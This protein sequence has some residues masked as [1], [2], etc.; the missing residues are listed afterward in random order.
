MN[1]DK[2]YAD[3]VV[4]LITEG[5]HILLLLKEDKN[6]FRDGGSDPSTQA[7]LS[8]ARHW[9]QSR[10]FCINCSSS[11]SLIIHHQ[12]VEFQNATGCPTFLVATAGPWITVLGVVI[13]DGVIVQRLMDCVWIGID[14]AL[15]V[16]RIR[17]VARIFS[18]LKTGLGE[19]HLY[20]ESV[21]P[22]GKLP[23]NSRYF[24]SITAYR[25]D[26]KLVNFEFMGYLENG[27]DC[28]TLR[29]QTCDEM[30]RRIVVKFVEHHGETAHRL[31]ADAGLAP[32]LFYYG[33]PH[34]DEGQPSY[35]PLLM[36][37]ME[38]VEGK[39]LAIAKPQMTPKMEESVQLELQRA[40][41]IL[42]RKGMVFGD[43]RA[44]LWV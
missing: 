17:H 28:V 2:T 20:Y 7:G 31:L 34:I 13:T 26:D 29:A 10:V 33:S 30:R 15:C 18:A 44:R 42:H 36:V 41:D 35:H 3:G 21:R 37:V 43:L 19:L 32:K 12:F 39:T 1:D 11:S 6:E 16:A 8:A 38:Y 22:N 5:R 40:L 14:S 4:E 24:P 23:V 9:A 25:D 27:P